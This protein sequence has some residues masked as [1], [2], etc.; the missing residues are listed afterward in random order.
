MGTVGPNVLKSV[1][2]SELVF[3]YAKYNFLIFFMTGFDRFS[4]TEV[5]RTFK[6]NLKITPVLCMNSCRHPNAIKS[7]HHG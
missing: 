2:N 4:H 3:L 5:I 1:Q 6:M 7:L